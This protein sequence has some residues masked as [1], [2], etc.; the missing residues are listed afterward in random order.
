MKHSQN[1]P[2]LMLDPLSLSLSSVV[3][4]TFW[5]VLNTRACTIVG[6]KVSQ[7][8]ARAQR[9]A[10]RGEAGFPDPSRDPCPRV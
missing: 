9:G 2:C 10:H 8:R 6:T 4:K 3:N 1:F 7:P 5:P